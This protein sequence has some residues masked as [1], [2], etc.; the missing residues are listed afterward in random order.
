MPGV[1]LL[2]PG[3]VFIDPN[4]QTVQNNAT[5]TA[6]GSTIVSGFGVRD[7]ILVVNIKAAPT[8]GSPSI[9]YSMQEIDPGDNATPVGS[10]VTGEAITTGPTTQI[11]QL[12]L[13]LTGVVEV[14]WTV[15]GASPSFTEVY[16][17]VVTKITTVDS[18]YDS[19]SAVIPHRAAGYAHGASGRGGTGPGDL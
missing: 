11:L 9:T 3:P 16:A 12:P 7:I 15:T 1:F 13:T 19:N 10:M 17:T 4:Q 18:G 2:A 5:V 8:G 14:S 6:S